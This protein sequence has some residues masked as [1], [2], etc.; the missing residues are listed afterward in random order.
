MFTIITNFT[1]LFALGVVLKK[2][3]IHSVFCLILTF[4]CASLLLLFLNIKFLAF[5]LLI[6]YTGVVL[7]L[8]LFV[9]VMIPP[10]NIKLRGSFKTGKIISLVSFF[11]IIMFYLFYSII[12][13]ALVD[14]LDGNH[15]SIEY[16]LLTYYNDMYLVSKFLYK[17]FFPHFLI[18]GFALF[19]AMIASVLI[20]G[21]IN[22][23]KV[24]KK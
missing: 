11:L 15:P 4:L 5:I 14:L 12:M 13:P 21:H 16:S 19:M 20:A 1:T 22:N 17:D 3:P 9:T 23:I 8:F 10:V 6:I 2:N 7:M 18:A 24:L